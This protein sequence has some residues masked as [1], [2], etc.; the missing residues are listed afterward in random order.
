MKG[1]VKARTIHEY[2]DSLNGQRKK[3]LTT[4]DA[5]IKRTVPRL[6][7]SMQ[8]GMIGYGS[9][10][11]RYS[12]GREGDWPIIALAS[13]KNYIS[14][15]AC[16][17]AN[18]RYIAEDYKVSLPKASIGKSCVRFKKLEDVDMKIIAKLLKDTVRAAAAYV[19][20]QKK[21]PKSGSTKN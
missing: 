7:A 20:S 13:Q 16:A 18:G 2:L 6:K 9:Y 8:F 4:L 14:L 10:H 15:Y 3:D 11:Y 1:N 12:S 17:T 5:L 21:L 19:A